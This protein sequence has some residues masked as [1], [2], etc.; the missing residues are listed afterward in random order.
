MPRLAGGGT[1][2]NQST[3]Y[4]IGFAPALQQ[5]FFFPF[6]FGTIGAGWAVYARRRIAHELSLSCSRL[7]IPCS[8]VLLL[9]YGAAYCQCT[10]VVAAWSM[11]RL[12][13]I[14]VPVEMI[15]TRPS[16]CT[17]NTPTAKLVN[18]I[19]ITSLSPF[20]KWRKM[21]IRKCFGIHA[22]SSGPS[23]AKYTRSA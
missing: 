17:T 9:V 4:K 16:Q 11:A 13:S 5:I 20:S 1:E 2:N 10:G 22:F 23:A 8:M 18:L 15:R 12:L 6:R 7:H 21:W 19:Y 3:R 14:Q